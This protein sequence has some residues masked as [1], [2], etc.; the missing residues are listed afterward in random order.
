M[1]NLNADFDTVC[2]HLKIESKLQKL[3]M[4]SAK[5]NKFSEENESINH[6]YGHTQSTIHDTNM[7]YLQ[8]LVRMDVFENKM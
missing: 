2:K 6:E 8:Y 1:E 3:N 5:K 4:S 7:N